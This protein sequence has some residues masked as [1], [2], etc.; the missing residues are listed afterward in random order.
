MGA[1]ANNRATAATG[2]YVS[3]IV[4]VVYGM[5]YICIQY[6][7]CIYVAYSVYMGWYICIQYLWC[8]YVAYRYNLYYLSVKVVLAN[9]CCI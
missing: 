9:Y 4:Y 6:L 1:G 5:V 3:C 8:I 7:W 2:I